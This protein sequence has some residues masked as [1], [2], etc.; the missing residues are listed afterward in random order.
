MKRRKD[1]FIFFGPPGSGKGSLSQL[2]VKRLGWHQFSTGIYAESI[3]LNKLRL[4]KQIDFAIKS[5]KLISDSLIIEM[6]DDWLSKMSEAEEP[7]SVIFDGFPRT[8]AQAQ[9]LHDLVK[10]HEQ[11]Q[12]K[13]VRLLLSDEEVLNRLVARSICKNNNCQSVYSLHKHSPLQPMKPMVCNECESPLMRRTDDEEKSIYERLRIYHKHEQDLLD[14][15]Q[16]VDK[17]VHAVEVDMPLED[18][19]AQFIITSR[20]YKRMITIKNTYAQEK[21]ATAGQL[22]AQLF[23]T[24]MSVD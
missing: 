2:C 21:M 19:F 14:F 23:V 18:V 22:L 16:K 5:G 9:A 10:S 7:M 6:V 1:I 13:L 8:V 3:L 4:A 11:V 12:L 20:V 15:S 24:L 17:L